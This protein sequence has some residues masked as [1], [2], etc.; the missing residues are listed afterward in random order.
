VVTVTVLAAVKLMMRQVSED[1]RALGAVTLPEAKLTVIVGLPVPVK[2]KW[3]EVLWFARTT[4][5]PGFPE[6]ELD[7]R[8]KHCGPVPVDVNPGLENVTPMVAHVKEFAPEFQ[9][10]A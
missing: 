1:P 6:D 5:C 10:A 8:T 9:V 3:L 4:C 7:L 2:P